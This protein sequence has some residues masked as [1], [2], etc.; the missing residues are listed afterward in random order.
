METTLSEFT[1]RLD[2][3]LDAIDARLAALTDL[4]MIT[5]EV[6]SL[7]A[8]RGL[9]AAEPVRRAEAPYGGRRVAVAIGPAGELHELVERA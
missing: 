8:V 7:D 5:W 6:D 1:A 2:A 4:A 9:L 3:R